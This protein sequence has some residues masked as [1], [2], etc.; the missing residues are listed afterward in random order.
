MP[1]HGR[2]Q[3]TRSAA[4]R[5]AEEAARAVQTWAQRPPPAWWGGRRDLARWGFG[6]ALMRL[7]GVFGLFDEEE[8]LYGKEGM[9][10]G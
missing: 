3:G 4:C 7:F 10:G 8:G 1:R 6:G 5:A 9:K 2:R